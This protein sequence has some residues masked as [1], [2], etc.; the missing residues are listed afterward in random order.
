MIVEQ[1]SE[2]GPGPKNKD[3]CQG[4]KSA[5]CASMTEAALVIKPKKKEKKTLSDGR[6]QL[7]K[8]QP[9]H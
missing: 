7:G 8:P 5:I 6:L 1:I 4:D 9:G 2:L 3:V